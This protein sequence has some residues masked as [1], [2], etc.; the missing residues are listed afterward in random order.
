MRE[1]EAYQQAN[2]TANE[3]IAKPSND[4]TR[5]ELGL[6]PEGPLRV[7]S[8][9]KEGVTSIELIRMQEGVQPA[10]PLMIATELL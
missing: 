4:D 2:E 3:P 10:T 8:K 7:Q 9:Y 5:I 1:R 6:H